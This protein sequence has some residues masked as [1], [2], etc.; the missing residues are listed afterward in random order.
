[1]E[2]VMTDVLCV[3]VWYQI[4]KHSKETKFT[5]GAIE[6]K[7]SLINMEIHDDHDDHDD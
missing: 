4:P 1:M 2:R 6:K 5:T 7:T 3:F